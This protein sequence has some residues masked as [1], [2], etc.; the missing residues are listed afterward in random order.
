MKHVCVL[1]ANGQSGKY[2]IQ[3]LINKNLEFIGLDLYVESK[4]Y[5]NG[6]MVSCDVLSSDLKKYIES[7]QIVV[8]ALEG[9]MLAFAKQI[10]SV[11]L[12]KKVSR[13]IWMTGMGIH[14]EIKGPRKIMLDR[15]VKAYP[16]YIEAADLVRDCGLCYTLLRCPNIYNGNNETYFLTT[17]DEQPRYKDVE[18]KAIAKCIYDMIEQNIGIN[19]SLGITN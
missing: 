3:E 14:Q 15:Y 2:I 6:K 18:R 19:Q 8:V 9:D 13:I 17:E 11:C 4:V 16:E 7:D 12:E 1:G 10:V 5:P